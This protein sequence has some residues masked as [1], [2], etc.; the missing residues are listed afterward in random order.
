MAQK[1]YLREDHFSGGRPLLY[2]R[3]SGLA[4]EV[5]EARMFRDA[6][7]ALHRYLETVDPGVANR[8]NAGAEA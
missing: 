1:P 2:V 7:E 5:G 6:R 8:E 4:G 3:A